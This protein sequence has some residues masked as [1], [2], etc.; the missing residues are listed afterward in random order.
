MVEPKRVF[1]LVWWRHGNGI[2]P[3]ERSIP[4]F[5]GEY[6]HVSWEVLLVV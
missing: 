2:A 4:P 5:A 6:S 1:F 3:S